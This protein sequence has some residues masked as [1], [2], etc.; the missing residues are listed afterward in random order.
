MDHC[1]LNVNRDR[2]YKYV[3]FASALPPLLFD[4]EKD[5]AE[6]HNLAGWPEYAEVVAR[7]AQR[8]LSW[9]VSHA[10]RVLT[11]LRVSREGIT[12]RG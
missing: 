8:M 5:P 7:M 11:G 9:R 4:L 12:K 1:S 3:H 10:E 6:H 2:H